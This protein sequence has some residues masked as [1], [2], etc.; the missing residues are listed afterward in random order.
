M[1]VEGDSVQHPVDRSNHILAILTR[2]T[3]GDSEAA[4]D[5]VILDINNDDGTPGLN[6]L[7]QPNMN[8]QE[9]EVVVMALPL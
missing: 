6:D 7:K 4:R 1:Q 2:G 9:V 3:V 8:Y 5:E